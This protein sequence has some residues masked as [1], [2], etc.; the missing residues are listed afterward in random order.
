[1]THP[2]DVEAARDAVTLPDPAEL[3]TVDDLVAAVRAAELSD[4]MAFVAR[5]FEDAGFQVNVDDG[6][7]YA[8]LVDR[9]PATGIADGVSF[10]VEQVS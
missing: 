7:A 6:I 5:V 1:M 4:G 10:R 8:K 2:A 3:P 9:D